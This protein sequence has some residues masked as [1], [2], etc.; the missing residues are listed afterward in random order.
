MF[1]MQDARARIREIMIADLSLAQGMTQLCDYCNSQ[2][3]DPTWERIKRLDYDLDVDV[4]YRWLADQLH[5]HPP[6]VEISAFWFGIFETLDNQMESVFVTYL[7]GS[8]RKPL[9]EMDIEWASNLDY[10]PRDTVPGV[11]PPNLENIRD[12]ICETDEGNEEKEDMISL[13]DYVLPFGYYVL[14]I[15]ELKSRMG[16]TALPGAGYIPVAV[17][18]DDED[19]IYIILPE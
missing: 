7:G 4:F 1:D 17:G 10:H 15:Q 8:R 13:A 5:L 9:S 18:Y 14:L 3:P 19:W 16:K 12:E 6:P 11:C 2:H